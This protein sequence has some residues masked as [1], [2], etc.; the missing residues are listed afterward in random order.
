[1]VKCLHNANNTYIGKTMRHLATRV[2]EHGT[3]SSAVSNHLSSCQT[4]RSNFSCNNFAIIDSGKCDYKI[5]VK[6]ALHIKPSIDRQYKVMN[7][8]KHIVIKFFTIVITTN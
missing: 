6:E 7:K 4:C 5:T 8:F 1:M 3:S 2:R